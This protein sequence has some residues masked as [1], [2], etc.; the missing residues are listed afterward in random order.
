[1]LVGF[2]GLGSEGAPGRRGKVDS[3]KSVGRRRRTSAAFPE[4][5]VSGLGTCCLP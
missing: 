3:D 2:G 1:M 5:Q 4:V